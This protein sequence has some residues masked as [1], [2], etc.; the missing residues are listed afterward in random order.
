MRAGMPTNRQVFLYNLTTAIA[1]LRRVSGV[2]K[3]DMAT[4]IYRFVAQQRLERTESSVE[5]RQGQ[6][7]IAN[8]EC[9]VKFFQGYQ[10]VCVDQPVGEF[11]PEVTALIC[12]VFVMFCD[13]IAG[14]FAVLTTFLGSAQAALRAAQLRLL[15]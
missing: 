6:V 12:D 15:L 9:Q 4:S 14:L 2:D 1:S 11:V 5:S 3:R 7:T 8:H 13:N 10:A